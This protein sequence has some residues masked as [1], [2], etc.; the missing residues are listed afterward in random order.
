ME[1]QFIKDPLWSRKTVQIWK[2]NLNL[3]TT[4]IYKWGF[5]KKHLWKKYSK[6]IK[7]SKLGKIKP[8][9][10]E[11]FR[12]FFNSLKKVAQKVKKF[13]NKKK[14]NKNKNTTLKW[15]KENHWKTKIIKKN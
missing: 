12:D 7:K 1:A 15:E 11:N 9:T 14:S 3:G 8:A 10:E 2:E 6:F 4:Q 13:S 5:D